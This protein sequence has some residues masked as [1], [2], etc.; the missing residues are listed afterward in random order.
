LDEFVMDWRAGARVIF[1]EYIELM[2]RLHDLLMDLFDEL[3]RRDAP[4]EGFKF[5]TSAVGIGAADVDDL[6]AFELIVSREDVPGEQT[7]DERAQMGHVIG[8]RP[9]AADQNLLGEGGSP[10]RRGEYSA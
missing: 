6:M 3:L 1:Q 4:L 2:E 7:P 10:F 9:G 5:H 8:I